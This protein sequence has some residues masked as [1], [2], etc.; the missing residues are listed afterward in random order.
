VEGAW[1]LSAA[2]WTVD[3]AITYYNMPNKNGVAID[4]PYQHV[5]EGCFTLP[6]PQEDVVFNPNLLKDP[7]EVDVRATYVYNF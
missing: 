3:P 1:D 7:V 6:F 4:P 5:P 2:E